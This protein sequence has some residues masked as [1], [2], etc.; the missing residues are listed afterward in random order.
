MTK[1]LSSFEWMEIRDVQDL[2]RLDF[3]V[4]AGGMRAWFL[5]LDQIQGLGE[6]VHEILTPQELERASGLGDVRGRRAEFVLSRIFLRTVLGKVL[7]VAPLELRFSYG[8]QGKPEL[9]PVQDGKSWLRFNFSHS[10]GGA[11]LGV[12]RFTAPDSCLGVDLEKIRP[13]RRLRE[14]SE[15]FFGASERLLLQ[16]VSGN[17]QARLFLQIWTAKEAYIKAIGSGV[18]QSASALEVRLDSGGKPVA[19]KIEGQKELTRGWDL[20]HVD[21][22]EGFAASIC[23]RSG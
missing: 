16:E 12:A 14:V 8:A 18:F 2:D 5:R 13:V 20:I 11:L 7:N 3:E 4:P 23:F 6:A 10:G 9:D 15:R 21:I 19:D 17:E 1:P 22:F